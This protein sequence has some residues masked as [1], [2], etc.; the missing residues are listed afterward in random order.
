MEKKKTKKPIPKWLKT[1]WLI[2]GYLYLPFYFGFYLLLK[3]IR[4]LLALAYCGMLEFQ[5]AKDILKNLFKN[6]TPIR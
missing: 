3:I 6:G 5:I 2:F 4:V 1:A